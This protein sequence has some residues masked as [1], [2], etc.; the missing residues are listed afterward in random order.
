M[1]DKKRK[2]IVL[3]PALVVRNVGTQVGS[4]GIL[5]LELSMQ[6]STKHLERPLILVQLCQRCKK[7]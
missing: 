4:I 7:S 2:Q 1:R 3:L 6:I 5:S